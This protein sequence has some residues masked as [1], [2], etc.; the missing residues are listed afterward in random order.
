MSKIKNNVDEISSVYLDSASAW[1][2]KHDTFT[3]IYSQEP[4]YSDNCEQ[5]Q[6]TDQ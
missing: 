6:L 1:G 4:I 3:P 2:V 5:R